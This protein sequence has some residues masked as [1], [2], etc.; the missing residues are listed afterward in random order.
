MNNRDT[1]LGPPAAPSQPPAGFAIWL[2]NR[3]AR[4]APPDLSARLEEEWLADL[5]ER[6]SFLSRLRFA[7]GCSWATRVIARDPIAFGVTA[8][9]AAVGHGTISAFFP[10]DASPFS[11]R[12]IAVFLVIALHLAVIYAF[13]NGIVDHVI[14]VWDKP[15]NGEIINRA[16]SPLPPPPGPRVEL[17][18]WKP[19]DPKVPVQFNLP[20]LTG[21]ISESAVLAPVASPH[22]NAMIRVQ[23]GPGTGFPDTEK[24]YPPAS[25]RL[26]EAGAA[27]VRVCVDGHG[28][29]INDPTIANSSGFAR[30]DAGALALAQ[31]G[32]GAYRS[33]LEN[34]QPVTSCYTFRV[35][36]QLKPL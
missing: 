8:H 31:A 5:A 11:R 33:T 19:V 23:G 32:S 6:S 12:S 14:K 25:K 20:S 34:G 36:F 1:L 29:L 17:T 28:H 22:T 9:S 16:Q 13:A 35:R 2:V 30:L 3:A 10:H 4:H 15:F 27:A 24:F 26:G 18:P 7:L 21:A